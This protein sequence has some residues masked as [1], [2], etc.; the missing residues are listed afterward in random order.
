MWFQYS[1][2]FF[3][4]SF[5]ALKWENICLRIKGKMFLPSRCWQIALWNK[6]VML[7]TTRLVS[8]GYLGKRVPGPAITYLR[9]SLDDG[10]SALPASILFPNIWIPSL[11][12]L[13]MIY[14]LHFVVCGEHGQERRCPAT[15]VSD[16]LLWACFNTDFLKDSRKSHL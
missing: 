9:E 4:V 2:S 3:C 13:K 12:H 16:I 1:C 8:R 10:R 6:V 14:S 7:V 11:I 5:R 15:S